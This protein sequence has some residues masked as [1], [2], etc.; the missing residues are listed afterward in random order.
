MG[1]DV[2]LLFQIAGVGF[3]V[4]IINSLLKQSKSEDYSNWVSLV[5]FVIVLLI[6]SMQLSDLFQKIKSVFLFQ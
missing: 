6:V 3:L 1:F 5:G 4:G 2:S